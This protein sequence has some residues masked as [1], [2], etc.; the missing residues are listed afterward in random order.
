MVLLGTGGATYCGAPAA[1]SSGRPSPS[2]VPSSGWHSEAV[3]GLQRARQPL[4]AL[5]HITTIGAPALRSSRLLCRA[6]DGG[7]SAGG[8]GRPEMT[9]MSREEFEKM[10]SEK[11]SSLHVE[12]MSPEEAQALLEAGDEASQ[13]TAERQCF[14][15]A[16]GHI[17]PSAAFRR[18]KN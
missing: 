5:S 7:G 8:S 10:L 14:T 17:R 13:V 11:G 3:R 16:Y 9:E 4:K 2:L 15:C 1:S 12:E 6:T 18:P